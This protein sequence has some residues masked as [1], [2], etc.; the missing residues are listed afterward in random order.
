VSECLYLV[1][2]PHLAHW[3]CPFVIDKG[4]V[5]RVAVV[6]IVVVAVDWTG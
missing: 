4:P 3:D 1:G 2:L 6:V 5:K